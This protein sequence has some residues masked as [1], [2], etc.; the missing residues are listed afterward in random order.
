MVVIAGIAGF[1]VDAGRMYVARNELRSFADSA[2]LS[3][4]QELDGTSG[5][6]VRARK[7]VESAS[8][9]SNKWDMATKTISNATV[10]FAKGT[11]EMSNKPD[12]AT[13]STSP[14]DPASY[15]FARVV[16]SVDVP[17]IFMR[18]GTSAVVVSGSAGQMPDEPLP[19]TA[20]APETAGNQPLFYTLRYSGDLD[21]KAA[22][23]QL[24]E[25]VREDSDP[26]SP[27]YAA[28]T[29]NAKGN[30]SRVVGLSI[31]DGARVVGFG[32]FFLQA[33]AGTAPARA[34]YVGPW[35]ANGA[36]VVRLVR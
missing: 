9:G 25:R 22:G 24:N 21:K 8:T 12:D 18:R 30:G 5:G 19:V 10:S 32:A 27:D 20:I 1:A 23:D 33:V 15:R 28:Y 36:H 6:I 31:G 4:A 2:A 11:D 35:A 29:R 13:W 17:M 7:A 14:A 26:I 34:E 3:A 16:A